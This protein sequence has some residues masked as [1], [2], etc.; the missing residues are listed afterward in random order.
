M[1]TI[2][3]LNS[4]MSVSTSDLIP[5]Y[6][7]GSQ[8][9]RRITVGQLLELLAS[10]QSAG[11]YALGIPVTKSS[12]F[13]PGDTENLLICAGSATI[14][15]LLPTASSFPGRIIMMKNV[16]A[17]SVISTA[18]NVV[19]LAGG[20]ASTSILPAGAGAKATLVSDGTNWVI[21][22]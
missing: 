14:T 6:A 13:S 20:S 2:N 8:T 4:S 21:M 3:Q 9:T 17:F 15:V 19:P 7:S 12:S 5:V 1:S 18:A 11:S 22:A 16:A 10:Q